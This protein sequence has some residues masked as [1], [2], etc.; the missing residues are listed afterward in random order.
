MRFVRRFQLLFL[1]SLTLGL[2]C[3]ELVE[4]LRLAD[5]VSNDFVEVSAA[6][7]SNGAE[8]AQ[9][10]LCCRRGFTVFDESI[11]SLAVIPSTALAILS[12]QDLLR[13]LSIQ[14]K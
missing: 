10:D 12:A 3:G 7:I 14:R 6:P 5:D 2:F 13:L 11:R 1:L 9:W 8:M 4:S